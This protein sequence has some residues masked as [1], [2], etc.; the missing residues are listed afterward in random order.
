M[1]RSRLP[2]FITPLLAALLL[3]PSSNAAPIRYQMSLQGRLVDNLG[4]PP[5]GP[6]SVL[7][8]LYTTDIGGSSVW[9]ETDLVAFDDNGV[10]TTTLGDAQSL[11]SVDFN[12]Q[13]WVGVSLDAGAT[14]FDPRIV[15]NAAPY[16]VRPQRHKSQSVHLST[17]GAD[18][19]L[20]AGQGSFLAGGTLV[21]PESG[22]YA[23]SGGCGESS[24]GTTS[25][26]RDYV[27]EIQG[28]KWPTPG[29]T[30]AYSRGSNEGGNAAGLSLSVIVFLDEGDLIGLYGRNLPSSGTTL[31]FKDCRFG[32]VKLSE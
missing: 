21:V 8:S 19:P 11:A 27:M 5:S 6:Q 16:A 4:D 2:L 13:Y 12:Q 23:L 14:E 10:F 30:P 28:T 7:F 1:K 24:P 15:L 22:H 18:I 26:P 29:I 25:Q 9:S 3:V 32:I 20:S 31:T 17:T